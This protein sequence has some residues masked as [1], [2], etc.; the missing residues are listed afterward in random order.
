M[1]ASK[2]NFLGIPFAATLHL[3]W[4]RRV[5]HRGCLFSVRIRWE[6]AGAGGLCVYTVMEHRL[7]SRK[8]LGLGPL[9]S[10]AWITVLRKRDTRRDFLSLSLCLSILAQ[11]QL[12]ISHTEHTA[13]ICQIINN[14]LQAAFDGRQT[15]SC[16]AA[17]G[18]PELGM[19]GRTSGM[20]NH[21]RCTGVRGHLAHRN[22]VSNCE[23]IG[24]LGEAYYLGRLLR[25]CREY[26]ELDV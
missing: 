3:G 21:S 6:R 14:T 22:E 2:R 5:K 8:V 12:A 24:W 10:L 23:I 20:R 11:E 13:A 9:V 19:K 17:C 16:A 15:N 7:S 18:P 4:R 1:T 26:F 25:N